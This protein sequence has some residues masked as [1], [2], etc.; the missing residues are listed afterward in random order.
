MPPGRGLWGVAELL[1]SK[2]H[3]DFPMFPCWIDCVRPQLNFESL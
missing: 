3:A 1:I 2:Q